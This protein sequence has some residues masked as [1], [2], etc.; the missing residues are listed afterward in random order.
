MQLNP[1]HFK[2]VLSDPEG[3]LS[4][5]NDIFKRVRVSRAKIVLIMTKKPIPIFIPYLL[6]SYRK[7]KCINVIL[8]FESDGKIQVITYNPYLPT[9]DK[10]VNLT[11]SPLPFFYDKTL[12]LLGSEIKGLF[13]YSDRTKIKRFKKNERVYFEGKDYNAIETIVSH[14]NG[15]LQV[16]TMDNVLFNP[17]FEAIDFD[18]R[19]EMKTKFLEKKDI[20]ILIKSEQFSVDDHIVE[21]LYPHTQNDLSF[22]VPKT[23]EIPLGELMLTVYTPLTWIIIVAISLGEKM[24]LQ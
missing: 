13:T 4:H 10:T 3:D 18:D 14:L 20:S 5:A 9:V 23:S 22:L 8:V 16:V 6:N 24:F 1:N 21:N 15:K 11:N 12:N 19:T 2:F 7:I 17:W